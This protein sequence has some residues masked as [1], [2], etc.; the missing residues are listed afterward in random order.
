MFDF[1]LPA[2]LVI[3]Q[4]TQGNFNEVFREIDTPVPIQG[5]WEIHSFI[6]DAGLEKSHILDA[7]FDPHENIWIATTEGLAQYDGYQWKMYL[8]GD[9]LPTDFIRCVIWTDKGLMVGTSKGVGIFDWEAKTFDT[10]DSQN[11]LPNSQVRRIIKDPDGTY[12]FCCDRWP[13]ANTQG[14]LTSWK[15]GIW[16]TYTTK[17]G[18]PSNYVQNYFRASDGRQFA[19]TN[20]GIA[21]M[22]GV[23]WVSILPEA[24]GMFWD[25]AEDNGTLFFSSSNLI[26]VNRDQEWIPFKLS[27]VPQSYVLC[28]SRNQTVL[29]SA[30]VS[31]RQRK[32]ME[33][34]GEKFAEIS[35]RFQ[36]ETTYIERIAESNDGSIWII[37]PDLVSSW[38]P[39]YNEWIGYD[40]V[41]IP[42]N[43]DRLKRV[44]FSG[45]KGTYVK[46]Q[47]QWYYSPQFYQLLKK[48]RDSNLWGIAPTHITYWNNDRFIHIPAKDVHLERFVFF[49]IDNHNAPW[50]LG[51]DEHGRYIVKSYFD[52]QIHSY[53]YDEIQSFPIISSAPNIDGV[54]YVQQIDEL[55]HRIFKIDRT[56]IE[57]IFI[58]E[59]HRTVLSN[60]KLYVQERF[61]WYFGT[62]GLH[63]FDKQD[64]SWKEFIEGE[65]RFVQLCIET[66]GVIWFYSAK[67]NSEQGTVLFI[68]NEQV[69]EY[70]NILAMQ[71]DNTIQDKVLYGGK[72][73]LYLFSPQT[74]WT[75]HHIHLP[76]Q[77]NLK[78]ITGTDQD[79]WL[80]TESLT[81]HYQPNSHPPKSFVSGSSHE[82]IKGTPV[83]FR[84]YAVLK[85]IPGMVKQDFKFSWS[86]N[87]NEWSAYSYHDQLQL[88]TSLLEVGKHQLQVHAMSDNFQTSIAPAV[89]S[90]QV[91]PVPIQNQ[92]WF[93]PSV[94]TLFAALFLL[95]LLTILFSI[96]IKNYSTG[97]ESLVSE[98]THA[99]LE[100]E[101]MLMH[102]QKMEAVGQLAGGI[103]HEFNNLLLIILGYAD[104]LKQ[105]K[106]ILPDHKNV[107]DLI[108]K[109]GQKA[110]YLTKQLLVFSRKQVNDPKIV[111]LN[112]IINELKPMMTQLIPENIQ[113][114][115]HLQSSVPNIYADPHQL[116]QVIMNLMLNA[117]DAVVQQGIICIQTETV[118]IR[119]PKQSKLFTL[120]PGNYVKFSVKDDGI[121]MS[122]ETKKKVF[123]P[124]FTTKDTGKG[125]GLGMSIVY[126]VVKQYDAFIEIESE[127][128]HGTTISIYF[129]AR[130]ELLTSPAVVYDQKLKQGTE[131]IILA[132]DDPEIKQYIQKS[133]KQA[134]YQVILLNTMLDLK[135]GSYLLK[136]DAQLLITDVVM[137]DISGIELYHTI[138]RHVPKIKVIFTS[139]YPQDEFED[140]KLLKP[141]QYYLC[142]PFTSAQLLQKVREILDQSLS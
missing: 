73:T 21:Q 132:E 102:S 16:K 110:S 17:D 122:E 7:A 64:Q 114:R 72:E 4:I 23:T 120:N 13:N 36:H 138:H 74:N 127:L 34:D 112:S 65:N 62:T 124:F 32:L 56:N 54:Y 27:P 33:W 5:E 45:E 96:K 37:G 115:Y 137:P 79:I 100:A 135:E 31:D 58:P 134:G 24:T 105:S 3:A 59:R 67:L 75:P 89:F 103:A 101:K 44:W 86:I 94:I 66:E 40:T 107:L 77:F 6:Q 95:C 80:G 11:H 8:T 82:V 26:Y 10:F 128:N 85:L 104:I 87:E 119:R 71:S 81:L 42:F 57:E 136:K 28:Q 41:S 121:G 108:Y 133:L 131:T 29:T 106:D 76:D 70:P 139:G 78:K 88:D 46:D 129:P 111:N 141:G 83:D 14:G 47:D 116:D 51:L 113:C 19:L 93:V 69:I 63:R 39:Q 118:F 97:L 99:L 130:N 52:D 125:T 18:L 142:K 90:F 92:F 38:Q 91:L 53:D 50:A 12:W 20:R 84:F 48:D 61:L 49:N 140:L 68:Q 2:C 43:Y 35:P 55:E 126:G 123:E 60:L 1:I 98:R 117:R 25:A 9:G 30:L 15:D 22:Q 109:T